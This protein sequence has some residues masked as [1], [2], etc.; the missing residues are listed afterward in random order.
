MV[1][2][3][4][5]R[6][7]DLGKVAVLVDTG[8]PLVVGRKGKFRGMPFE[9]TGRAQFSH[10]AGGVWDEWYASFPNDRWGWLAEAQGKFYLTFARHLP[11]QA[12][13]PDPKEIEPSHRF[14]VPGVGELVANEIGQAVAKSA[15]GE[16]PYRLVPGEPLDYID[17]TGAGGKFATIDYSDDPPTVYLG[18]ETT[19]DELGIPPEPAAE[20][21]PQHVPAVQVNCPKCGGVL[22]LKAPDAAE[23]VVCPYCASLLDC[24]QGKLQFL[25]VLEPRG[26][27]PLI[28]LGAVGRL[29]GKNYTVIGFLVRHVTI[30][31]TLYYWQEFL[32]YSAG[33]GFRWLVASDGHWN[34]VAS[35]PPGEVDAGGRIAGYGRQHFRLFQRATAVVDELAGEFYWKVRVGESVD[36]SDFVAPPRMLS[37]EV[38]QVQDASPQGPLRRRGEVNWSLGKYL[39]RDEVAKAFK[40]E[41]LPFPKGIGPNQ[42]FGAKAVYPVWAVLMAVAI[43]AWPILCAL[44]P[45]RDVITKTYTLEPPAAPDTT[46]T[47]F[48]SPLALDS[49]RTIHIRVISPVSNSWLFVDGDLYNEE[50]GLT[51]PFSAAVEYYYGVDSDGESWTEGSHEADAYVSAVPGGNY[52]LRLESQW[53]HPQLPTTMTVQVE[54]AGPRLWFF[55]LLLLMLSILPIIT[56]FVHVRFEAAR[57]EDSEF[58]SHGQSRG[59][60]ED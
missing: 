5:Q 41:H 48:E 16:I 54:E 36:C 21:E 60:G 25:Q 30:A 22:D 51:Q 19:L 29:D 53:E 42:P 55:L 23:R 8:S 17:L 15:E 59:N 27:K 9:L 50:T 11:P 18:Q 56:I 39:S 31:R 34:F 4:D 24:E 37:R 7:E 2:R 6:L 26:T 47:V 13:L 58:D 14:M 40:A 12:K 35:I 44:K 38:S 52:T 57:W 32:L 1:A 20:R 3:G 46:R 49:S 28:P 43:L 33:V 45:P 10:Q